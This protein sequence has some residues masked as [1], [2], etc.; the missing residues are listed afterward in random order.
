MKLFKAMATVAGLTGLSRIAGFVRDVLTASMLGAGPIA[1]AFF[2]A[3]K[4]PNFFRK[5]TAEGAFSVS[6]IPKYAEVLEQEGVERS[7]LFASRTMTMMLLILSLLTLLFMICMP[8]IIY[9][10]APGFEVGTERY[11]MAVSMS[12]ITF[13]YLLFMSLTALMGGVLNAHDRFAPFAFA[14]VLFNLCL[15]GMLLA[16]DSFENAGYAMSWGIILA[17]IL[18]FSFL[19]VCVRRAGIGITFKKPVLSENIK[20]VFRRMGPGLIGAGVLQINLFA[21]LFIASFLQSGA[22]SYLYYADRLNQLPLGT[23]G[24]AVGTALLPMLTRA[25]ASGDK[26]EANKLF[27]RAL[28]V[29]LLLGLPCAVGLFIIPH[30]LITVLFEHGAFTSEDAMTTAYVVMGYSVGLPAYIGVK[31]LSTVFWSRGDTRTPVKIA[32]ITMSCNI[33]LSLILIQFIGVM[34][35]TLATGLTGWLQYFLLKRKLPMEITYDQRFKITF[36]KIILCNLILAVFLAGCL[37]SEP[38][39]FNKNTGLLLEIITLLIIIFSSMTIY[40]GAIFG[41]R[42]VKTSDFKRY[43]RRT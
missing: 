22:I 27:N 8:W 36:P 7:A 35:I 28:E 18:Q 19:W 17:G 33:I 42:V 12:Q 29:C 26:E 23:I 21:D 15:I 37:Y 14:P 1:D 10:I 34:G 4:L 25:V 38:L 9:G 31:V 40:F 24:I 32:I 2:V 3:L 5:V 39:I 13:P 20:E 11:D 6:F 41:L 16:S 43:F 30:I